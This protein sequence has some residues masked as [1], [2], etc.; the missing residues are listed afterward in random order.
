MFRLYSSLFVVIIL[1]QW[2][3]EKHSPSRSWLLFADKEVFD[4]ECGDGV[5]PSSK[6]GYHDRDRQYAVRVITQEELVRQI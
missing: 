4:I 6:P 3:V 5:V 2:L 1:W